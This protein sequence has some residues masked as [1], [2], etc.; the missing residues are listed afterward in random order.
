[1][2]S[3]F[4]RALCIGVFLLI[5]VQFS[6]RAQMFDW[7]V[8][9][10]GALFNEITCLNA[11]S[12]GNLYAAGYGIYPIVVTDTLAGTDTLI[13]ETDTL[14]TPDVQLLAFDAAGEIIWQKTIQ[15]TGNDWASY[16]AATA[17]NNFF[18]AGS[19][20]D[21]LYF[22]TDT[23]G[24][25][26]IS[27]SQ[28]FAALVNNNSQV[29]WAMQTHGTAT[30]TT[31]AL[32]ADAAGNA[33][34]GLQFS[35]TLILQ[36][37]TITATQNSNFMVLKLNQAGEV[38]WRRTGSGSQNVTLTAITTDAEGNVYA[39]GYFTGSIA[40]GSVLYFALDETDAFIAKLDAAGNM[41]WLKTL[42][43]MANQSFGAVAAGNNGELYVGGHFNESFVL[44]TDTVHA[45]GA[46]TAFI[47][48]YLPGN[49]TMQWLTTLGGQGITSGNCLHTDTN[50]NA[51]LTGNFTQSLVVNSDT[52]A[53][54]G[55]EDLFVWKVLPDGNS[56]R[57]YTAGG[58]YSEAA[59]GCTFDVD[60]NL[61]IAGGFDTQTVL[62]GDTLFSQGS[63]DYFLARL[64]AL[65][66]TGIPT[67][68]ANNN[69]AMP[70]LVNVYPN[71]AKEV[72]NLQ[73]PFATQPLQLILAQAD[74]KIVW[75]Q[76]ATGGQTLQL[77]VYNLPR[78]MYVL[79][80]YNNLQQATVK[81]MVWQ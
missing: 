22:E 14:L 35:D 11:G 23:L 26:G 73:I 15:G 54:Q 40:F 29:Q 53:A 7:A 81:L 74:G 31:A 24:T 5:F 25:P 13:V 10:G 3:R 49:G 45:L 58:S 42:A 56:Q 20:T 18:V 30:A 76:T 60:G 36:A 69:N 65:M 75:Q 52:I 48:R 34:L 33:L 66:L 78:G 17:N 21:T 9:G 16:L 41:L 2:F 28:C 80:L 70:L 38:V 19:F 1:M 8:S 51:W 72:A 39:C 71:P 47:A 64:N 50:G 32:A 62:E 79:H 43:A 37:D 57:P 59:N 46:N 44:N 68:P 67:Q 27:Q 12:D 55:E 63:F 6:L 4:L 77:P 61:Y